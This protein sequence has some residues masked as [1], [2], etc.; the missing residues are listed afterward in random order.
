MYAI[1]WHSKNFL[2]GEKISLIYNNGIPLIF[3]TRKEAREYAD[4]NYGYIKVRKDLR[5]APFGFRMPKIVKFSHDQFVKML[6][7]KEKY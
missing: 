4:K 5:E 2:H 3:R 6:G 1:F 7:I